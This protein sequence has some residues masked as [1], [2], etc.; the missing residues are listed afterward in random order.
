MVMLRDRGLS[1]AEVLD[2]LEKRFG[3]SGHAEKAARETS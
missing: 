3:L 1:S 2:C